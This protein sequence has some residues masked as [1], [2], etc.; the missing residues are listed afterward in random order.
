MSKVIIKRATVKESFFL[1]DEAVAAG[2][3]PGQ[4]FKLDSTGEK[5]LLGTGSNVYFVGIDSPTEIATPPSG[6]LIT[7]IYGSGTKFIIDHSEEVSAGSA[8]RAYAA[9]VESGAVMDDLYFNDD[10]KFTTVA[11]SSGSAQAKMYMKP[12]S[13]NNYS[14]GVSLRI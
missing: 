13:A 9:D 1:T 12:T 6:S 7:G 10:S 3:L 8:T 5:A 14:L 4:G 11:P 2:W